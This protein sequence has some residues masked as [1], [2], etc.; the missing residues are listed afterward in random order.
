MWEI[1]FGP[2]QASLLANA[3]LALVKSSHPNASSA[4]AG[5]WG[6]RS[7]LAS[8]DSATRGQM[9]NDVIKDAREEVW[10]TSVAA[11]E[12]CLSYGL[13][14]STPP[15]ARTL[16]WVLRE[17]G[18]ENISPRKQTFA[19]DLA[20]YLPNEQI[21]ALRS[22]LRECADV[23]LKP[24]LDSDDL[25]AL[26]DHDESSELPYYLLSLRLSNEETLKALVADVDVE[27]LAA[28]ALAAYSRHTA[29]KRGARLAFGAKA[30]SELLLA[31]GVSDDTL[32]RAV[33]ALNVGLGIVQMKLEY[34]A[35]KSLM[36]WG[37]GVASN[38]YY[39]LALGACRR[40]L[41]LAAE[42]GG[43]AGGAKEL[44]PVVDAIAEKA[45]ETLKYIT[46]RDCRPTAM[47]RSDSGEND[48]NNMHVTNGRYTTA[49]A[50]R[51]LRSLWVKDSSHNVQVLGEALSRVSF[52][53]ARRSE[54][55]L[56]ML[57]L[58]DIQIGRD[59]CFKDPDNLVEEVGKALAK[60]QLAPDIVIVSG[61]LVSVASPA[62]FGQATGLLKQLKDS[63]PEIRTNEQIIIAPGNHEVN[64]D[65]A[66]IS[67][68]VLKDIDTRAGD[69]LKAY[70]LTN[71][72]TI[73]ELRNFRFAPFAEFYEGFYEGA[74]RYSL[75][76]RSQFDIFPIVGQSVV[77]ATFNSAI[78][79]DF[80]DSELGVGKTTPIPPEID[81]NALRAAALEI[82][83]R[84]GRDCLRIAVFH[85][86][87]ISQNPP[88]SDDNPDYD[89]PELERLRAF[90]AK[91]WKQ[92]SAAG[93]RLCLTGHLHHLNGEVLHQVGTD[94]RITALSAG[95]LATATKW[96]PADVGPGF[97]A[98]RLRRDDAKWT[99]EQTVFTY[100]RDTNRTG[101]AGKF[102]MHE[103]SKEP[104]LIVE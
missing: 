87:L 35:H 92:L 91:T 14:S 59:F 94:L 30:L 52:P 22:Q 17:A 34:G 72:E 5:R 60:E 28:W 47:F 67:Y 74:R 27:A 76:P 93:F 44:V 18:R 69:P 39:L 75:R 83:E 99:A 19:W 37:S 32:S 11:A 3:L 79:D 98:I 73:P 10:T 77:I 13:P 64:W 82:D 50:L 12:V 45:V 68:S 61:D 101:F 97:S 85:H 104:I 40:N 95:S 25:P 20:P 31:D 2:E 1:E 4:F 89:H 15:I 54:R 36:T 96:R 58:S 81:N 63:L 49:V 90:T 24:A 8:L 102:I 41:Y 48:Y 62:E 80:V 88:I 78:H 65:L 43:G 42:R 21:E 53:K 100:L 33:A 29:R 71:E 6:G 46:G 86:P 7:A 26:V 51:M 9:Q 38:S 55:D 16:E 103:R 57:H 66:R 84:F 56:C 70:V 23:Y